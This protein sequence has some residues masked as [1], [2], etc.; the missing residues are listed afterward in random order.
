MHGNRKERRPG[1]RMDGVA[2]P[3]RGPSAFAEL[4][5]HDVVSRCP[6][7]AG[8]CP[9]VC[10]WQELWPPSPLVVCRRMWSWQFY[11]LQRSSGTLVLLSRIRNTI[12]LSY[13]ALTAS[14]GALDLDRR[15]IIRGSSQDYC[16]RS[17][18]HLG[19]WLRNTLSI[20]GAIKQQYARVN[21]LLQ[22]CRCEVMRDDS[23]SFNALALLL[24]NTANGF[25]EAPTLWTTS[26]YYS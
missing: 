13:H 21:M 8:F 14:Q 16:T 12:S 9:A 10:N 18:F 7:G 20:G 26:A 22:L 2:N 6:S 24:K 17:T 5:S 11:L 1:N 19:Q 3:S 23:R 4:F 25:L 15:H